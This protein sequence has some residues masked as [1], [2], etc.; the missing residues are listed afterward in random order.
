MPNR[1]VAELLRSLHLVSS[2]NG[3][4]TTETGGRSECFTLDRKA[5]IALATLTG[6]GNGLA[7]MSGS[8]AR[9]KSLATTPVF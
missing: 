1:D 3:N 8:G 6:N 5:A 2:L 7:L 4:A 9:Q